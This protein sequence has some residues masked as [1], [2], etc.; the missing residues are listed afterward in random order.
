MHPFQHQRP[1]KELS[2]HCPGMAPDQQHCQR[3]QE[4]GEPTRQRL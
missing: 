2:L 1:F 3:G 4:Q